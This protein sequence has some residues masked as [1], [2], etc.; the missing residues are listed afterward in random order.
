MF[1]ISVVFSSSSPTIPDDLFLS[2]RESNYFLNKDKNPRLGV[3]GE[4]L[5]KGLLDDFIYEH[6]VNEK[7]PTTED[8]R[9][10]RGDR[11]IEHSGVFFDTK[12]YV[13]FVANDV[14]L[15]GIALNRCATEPLNFKFLK[16]GTGYFA[17]PFRHLLNRFIGNLSEHVICQLDDQQ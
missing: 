14:V 8:V 6:V 9:N 15:A 17:G 2:V 13:K 16:Y 11:F 7:R 5:P 1:V 4:H 10:D 3:A 12:A